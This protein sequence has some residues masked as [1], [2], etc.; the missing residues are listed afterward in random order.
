MDWSN[1]QQVALDSVAAWLE[2]DQEQ[3]FRLFGYAGT[4]K[5]T[6][7][8]VFAEQC[9]GRVLFGCF[10]GKAALVLR[11]KGC[12]GASTVHRMIYTPKDKSRARLLELEEEW[13]EKSVQQ[14]LDQAG[15]D[16]LHYL[17]QE[18][19]RTLRRPH[20]A[21][22]PDS[23]AAEADLIVIDEVSMVGRQ[24]GEDLLSFGRPVLVLGDPAQLPPVADGGYFTA[25]EPDVMLTQIHRQAAGSPV[26]ELA[27]R[28]RR[29]EVLPLGTWGESSVVERGSM[30][31]AQ[32]AGYDQ[33]LVGRNKT[34][35]AVNRR[36]R[37]EILGRK[38]HLP[39]PG[40]KLVCLRNDH[41][42]GLLNGSQWVVHES[43]VVDSDT[44]GLS[45][46][47][48]GDKDADTIMVDA[49]R[50][51][52]E[53]REI[54]FWDRGSAQEFDHGYALT[55]HKAQ[56]SAWRR[57]LVV[58][59]SNCF[60]EHARRWLYTAVTRASESVTVVKT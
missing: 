23:E 31:I 9:G 38:T 1:E 40:D 60:R 12:P 47:E 32:A 49:H 48:S 33:I 4:G 22:N 41:E 57:V 55:T 8:R 10:T 37:E 7:A 2:R 53:D 21:V 54:P 18:E 52:F 19:K 44:V 35:R 6:L 36:I 34:R 26:I 30:A 16:H 20:F 29:G 17:I 39:E 59:E 56:G 51:P 11:Q 43:A 58:D 42:V 50:A 15:L 25:D 27:T 13:Q 24:M 28:V 14:P 45:I 46:S 5:T 3:V